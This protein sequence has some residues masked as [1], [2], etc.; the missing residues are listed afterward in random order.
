MRRLW[1]RPWLPPLPKRLLSIHWRCPTSPRENRPKPAGPCLRT[2]LFRIASCTSDL[3][4]IV[5]R[6]YAL[7]ISFHTAVSQLIFI[8]PNSLV[9]LFPL[10]SPFW[11]PL[12]NSRSSTRTKAEYF[13][14]IT[15]WGHAGDEARK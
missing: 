4:S 6:C 14:G 12:I 8:L 15:E 10:Q 1:E 3:S 11:T 9:D 13:Q 5:R 7:R 2:P